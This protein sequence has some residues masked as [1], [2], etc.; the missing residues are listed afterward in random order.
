MKEI[1]E[2]KNLVVGLAAYIQEQDDEDLG[3]W[4][5]EQKAMNITG[6]STS[7]LYRLRKGG[8]VR[9]SFIVGKGMF[10][11]ASDFKKMLDTNHRLT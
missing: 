6:L 10:Y 7:S 2:L 3:G 11:M 4:I 8:K 1:L 9:S 5:C